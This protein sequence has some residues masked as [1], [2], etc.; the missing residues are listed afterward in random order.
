MVAF[1][2]LA[3]ESRDLGEL[4]TRAVAVARESLGTAAATL[5]RWT[6][7]NRG[8]LVCAEGAVDPAAEDEFDLPEE[9][10]PWW[11]S[12]EPV[13][14]EGRSS[15]TIRSGHEGGTGAQGI[16]SLSAAVLVGDWPWGRLIVHE[17]RPR[18]WL[19]TEVDFLRSLATVLA[20]ALDRV[21][22]D[23][24]QAA[25]AGFGRFALQTHDLDLTVGRAVELAMEGLDAPLCT[26]S[27]RVGRSRL[28]SICVRGPSVVV[29]GQ[30]F[31]ISP[32]LERA[33]DV[34]EPL[35]V[36][37]WSRETRFPRPAVG[38]ADGVMSALQVS[39]LVGGRPWG[40]LIAHDLRPRHWREI[41]VDF[42]QSLANVLAAAVERDRME[43]RLWARTRQLQQV[44]VPAALPVLEGVELAARYVPTNDL[45]VGGDWYDVL[46]LP[47]GGIALVMGDVEGHDSTAAAVMGQ[48][49]TVLGAYVAEG[50]PPAEVL[51][52]TSAFV[53]GHTDRLVSCCYAELYPDQRT[54]TCASAGHPAPVLLTPDGAAREL[55]LEP[56]LLLGVEDTPGYPER[57]TVL[58]AGSCLV[59][60]T[61]GMLDGLPGVMYSDVDSLGTTARPA[62]D[63]PVEALADLLVRRPPG[64]PAL[65]D[66][67]ALLL[68]RLVDGP[69][70]CVGTVS[71]VFG[72]CPSACHSARAFTHDLLTAWDLG[73]LC[74][75]AVLAVSELVTNA[76][77]H[78]TSPIRL[79]LS[80]TDHDRVRIGVNDTS[81]SLPQPTP[82]LV[83]ALGGRGLFIVRK[84]ADS[85]GVD[86]TPHR[87]GK[88]V[89]LELAASAS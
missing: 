4:T 15:P 65:R 20:V 68:V 47:D 78:T 11:T 2:R 44:L 8:R 38:T 37:D 56:G 57:T 35:L 72:S 10:I 32:A 43:S 54:L 62:V 83:D 17:T 50:Y 1:G 55:P 53:T 66:D 36:E 87:S 42:I 30:E 73:D 63:G 76:L 23:A 41:E 26:L 59:M 61:D 46:G 14:A 51:A 82:P 31:E 19:D 88:T 40:R 52:R 70:G 45:E 34:T 49:R 84:L 77:V 79:I 25:V 67:A 9:T 58:P 89:W 71:R 7:L 16:S 18:R 5:V 6:T 69:G 80:R 81:D 13:L 29:P 75:D 22:A 64:A 12:P 60:V 21:T 28:R 74:Q 85:W 24:A 86:P 39:V 33:W 3:L 27:R 48:V